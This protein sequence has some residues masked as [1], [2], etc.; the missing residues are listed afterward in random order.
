[1]FSNY[2]ELIVLNLQTSLTSV[3]HILEARTSV[4]VVCT[5]ISDKNHNSFQPTITRYAHC[6][7]CGAWWHQYHSIGEV[8]LYSALS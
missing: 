7:R 6:S 8:D 5:F 3:F 1:M 4:S 2:S